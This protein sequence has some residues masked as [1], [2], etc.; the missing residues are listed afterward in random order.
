MNIHTFE[1]HFNKIILQRGYDYFINEYVI[2]VIAIDEHNW[3]AEVEGS[4]L[5]IVNVELEE[6]GDI[7]YADCD[8]PY[9]N[10][11]KHMVAVLYTIQEQFNKAPLVSQKQQS[12]LQ[13][14]LVAQSK[15][16]LIN[17]IL[18]VGKSTP[19][20]LKELEIHLMKP[21]DI[22]AAS[23][24]LIVHHLR[25]EQDRHDNFI[26]QHRATKALKGIYTTIHQAEEQL[27]NDNYLTAIELSFLC[28]QYTIE[29]GQFGDDSYGDFSQALDNSIAVIN[30][31]IQDGVE[32]WTKEQY[33]TVYQLVIHKA[34]QPI[35]ED[36]AEYRISLLHACVPLCVDDA[37]EEQFKALLQSIENTDETRPNNYMLQQIKLH[38]L[39]T[40]YSQ[41]EVEAFLEQHISNAEMRDQLIQ[42]AMNR[43]DYE[44]VVQLTTDGMKQHQLSLR[45]LRKWQSNAF[46]A[47]KHLGH[48]EEMRQ[49]ASQLLL[50]GDYDFYRELKALYS[51]EQWPEALEDLLDHLRNSHLYPK[52]IVEEQHTLRM[53]AYCQ[54]QPQRIIQYYPYIKE[55]YY[56]EVCALFIDTITNEAKIASNRKKYQDVCHSINKMRQAGYRVEAKQLIEDLLQAY[57]KRRA[58]IEELKDIQK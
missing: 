57:P 45:N 18:T 56:E 1:K 26:P 37:I 24:K 16:N 35:L 31:A 36:W 8:C 30:W 34:M 10:D 12:T 23:E 40:K 54:E 11:C 13:Q 38:L 50:N 32:I 41:K 22:I 3:Q 6:N 28:L 9:D 39:E 49:L 44:K 46:I 15:E 29:A 7:T 21:T 58:F 33:E 42:S 4:D 51:T 53:L 27:E 43:G 47:H 2:D 55:Y 14:L 48:T 20:F 19:Q 5:Y 52:I 17:L 25:A